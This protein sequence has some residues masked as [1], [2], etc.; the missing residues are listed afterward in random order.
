MFKK[1]KAL[2]HHKPKEKEPEKRIM[3]GHGGSNMPEYQPCPKCRGRSK[4]ESKTMGGA[5]Y[6]CNKHGSFFV[7]AR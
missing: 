1:I 3:T 7:R 5:N 6:H 2:P 4:R